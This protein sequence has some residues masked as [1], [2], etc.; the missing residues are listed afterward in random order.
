M[1]LWNVAGAP[2]RPDGITRDSNNPKRVRKAVSFS[3]PLFIRTS[4]NAQMISILEKSFMPW[5][6]SRVSLIS[7][8]G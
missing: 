8:S 7:G 5:K 4:M 1:N 2:V 6:L 3:C